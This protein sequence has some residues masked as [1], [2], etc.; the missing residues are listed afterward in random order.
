[1]VEFRET[2]FHYPGQLLFENL[3]YRFDQGQ[4]HALIGP[5]GCGKTTLL[6]L[7]AGLLSPRGGSVTVRNEP[8][9]RGRRNTAVILQDHGLFPWKNAEE[10]VALGMTLRR[11]KNA[12]SE[13]AR[14]LEEL[15][16]GGLEKRY[17]R[18]LSGGE[19][20]RLAVARALAI[21][22]DLLL[23]DEPFA[24]LDAMT[25]EK[26]QN[27]LREV[28]DRRR[29]TM[30]LITHSIEEAVFLG[31]T[32]HVMDKSGGLTALANTN[33]PDRHRSTRPF[34]DQTVAVRERLE[35]AGS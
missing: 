17:P 2:V 19:R 7:A 16:L 34:F 20:Q 11:Q 9:R 13:T 8:V 30:I 25:R 5:S 22:P 23:L 31:D 12:R 10:N 18:E 4:I 35:A 32:I 33:H 29:L 14:Y 21:E 27:R 26:L 3:T 6:Y 24:S 28:Q 1:M 15:G